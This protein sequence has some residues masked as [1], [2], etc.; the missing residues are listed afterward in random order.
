MIIIRRRQLV[1]LAVIVGMTFL[2]FG[3]YGYYLASR[4]TDG[5]EAVVLVGEKLLFAGITASLGTAFAIF[6]ILFL[7][8][9]LE[10]RMD[11]LIDQGKTRDIVPGRDFVGLGPLGNKLTALFNLLGKLNEQKTRKISAMQALAA[12]LVRNMDVH[13]LVTDIKGI[14]HYVSDDLLDEWE[15]KRQDNI[16]ISVTEIV[17]GLDI[18]HLAARL[19]KTRIPVEDS[20][21][22]T[23]YSCF[24]I[25]DKTDEVA[26]MAF[27]IGPKSGKQ[28]VRL[29]QAKSQNGRA[30]DKSSKLGEIRSNLRKSRDGFK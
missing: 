18:S 4:L 15:L 28:A 1:L 14:I 3:L 24:P 12:F 25:M 2:A 23:Q 30:G 6:M 9:D 10:R 7:A 19:I 21:R 11:R 26:Y 13:A 8:T 29:E 16:N 20:A 27:L 17:E 5:G 22:K